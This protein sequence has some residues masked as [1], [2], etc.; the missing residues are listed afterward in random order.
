MALVVYVPSRLGEDWWEDLP[1]PG[2]GDDG[3][4]ITY[5]HGT[6]AFVYAAAG[7]S[8]TPGG[9]TTQ[10]QYNNAGAF[11]GHS[12]MA[13]DDVNSRLTVVGGLV[14]PSMR[15]ASDSTTAL[16]WQ[17]AAGTAVVTVDT[18]NKYIGINTT[19]SEALHVQVV[20]TPAALFED[21]YANIIWVNFRSAAINAYFGALGGQFFWNTTR[22]SSGAFS[23]D[24][25]NKRFALDANGGNG[26]PL[27]V[28]KSGEGTYIYSGGISLDRAT[29]YI[30][31]TGALALSTV[32][33]LAID[34][35]APTALLDIAASTTARASLRIRS[36][37]RPT[38]PN[39][40]DLWTESDGWHT[41]FSG[42]EY[43]L[44]MTAA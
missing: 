32:S 12:G 37:V 27:S 15:P 42:V 16:Q 24:V 7:G 8:G 44:G 31:C 38:S 14:A 5:D 26:V 29:Y 4:A 35:S 39:N 1:V 6:G 34:H 43:I 21:P 33:G 23:L 28:F 11:A 3:K 2:A 19:P 41:Y 17:N 36:G 13:Y 18:T 22:S 30:S 25:T 10:V 40:G 9:S 20:N